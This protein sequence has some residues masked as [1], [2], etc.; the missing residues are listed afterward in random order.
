VFSAFHTRL[1]VADHAA[2]RARGQTGPTTE[3]MEAAED[4]E[5]VEDQEDEERWRTIWSRTST[6]P[7]PEGSG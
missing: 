1:G 4:H 2:Q 7:Q 5:R 3:A 6:R